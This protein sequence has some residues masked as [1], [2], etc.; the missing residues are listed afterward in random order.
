L[1]VVQSQTA[2]ETMGAESIISVVT[3]AEQTA[4]AVASALGTSPCFVLGHV[5][6]DLQDLVARMQLAPSAAVVVDIASGPSRLL[7]RL[8]S[9]TRRFSQT[10]FIVLS[11]TLRNNLVLEAM[12][13]GARHFLLKEAIASDLC[14]ILRRLVSS[15]STAPQEQGR[16]ITVLSA[17]GGCGAT[18]LAVNLAN[19]L[20]IL[21]SE[22]AL[23]VDL[24]CCYGGVAT[25]L[26]VSS[27]YGVA[28]VLARNGD[29]DP[30][31]IRS[32]ALVY[33]KG[34]H[35]LVSP[36]TVDL[37]SPAPLDYLRLPDVIEVCKRA[38]QSTVIDAPRV[39]IQVAKEL[40]GASDMTL[41]AL[42]MTVKDIGM[43]RA[44]MGALNGQGISSGLVKPLVNR[45]RKR[46]SMI[47]LEEAEKALG[48]ISL[49]CVGNDYRSAIKGLNYG[50]PLA[51]AAPRSA[52][53]RGLRQLAAEVFE[54][55]YKP[56]S[57]SLGES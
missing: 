43:A 5:C 41:I 55:L 56:L 15:G 20:H 34:L 27:R 33:S 17:S 10:R 40:V 32:T 19:E 11:D 52:L 30:Q 2:A 6:R 8:D 42:Q 18:T 37:A 16:V 38:Y 4:N 1:A 44:M 7:K 53:H 14:D 26:G 49:R 23:L 13:A 47:T 28:D 36:A 29:I 35:V 9:V 45:Y 12:Q 21:A 57:H 50:R 46:G 39:S 31:L 22:S 24:D 25:Y 3:E 54:P 51:Q 48:G